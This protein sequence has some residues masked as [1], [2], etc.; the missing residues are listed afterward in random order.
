MYYLSPQTKLHEVCF[1]DTNNT[2]NNKTDYSDLKSYRILSGDTMS[3]GTGIDD[4]I[5]Y[6]HLQTDKNH[7]LPA[8]T[9]NMTE[10]IYDLVRWIIDLEGLLLAREHDV[11]ENRTYGAVRG[12]G[13]VTP[14]YSILKDLCSSLIRSSAA[15]V[16]VWYFLQMINISAFGTSLRGRKMISLPSPV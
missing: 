4:A 8:N 15:G 13:L 1:Q 3:T 2:N 16:K 14:S 12:R 9:R 11:Y 10:N 6:G 5:G 7:I